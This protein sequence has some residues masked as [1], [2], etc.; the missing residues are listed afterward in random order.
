LDP[1]EFITAEYP[2]FEIT[3]AYAE[4][5]ARKHVKTILRYLG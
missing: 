2:I 3:D 4:S 1:R 5:V